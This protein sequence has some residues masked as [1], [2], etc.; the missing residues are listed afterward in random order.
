M[1]T[2]KTYHNRRLETFG[3]SIISGC[4]SP[5]AVNYNSAATVDDGSCIFLP[6]PVPGCM[7][8]A[9]SNFSSSANIDDGSCVFGSSSVVF[10]TASQ[11]T[12]ET[13]IGANIFASNISSLSSW[14]PLATTLA[15][16]TYYY[17][18]GSP[19]IT[20]S[21]A[22][23]LNTF[24]STVGATL[25]MYYPI[26]SSSVAA[27]FPTLLDRMTSLFT[28]ALIQLDQESQG[29]TSLT[30]AEYI[31]RSKQVMGHVPAIKASW[32]TA[33]IWKSNPSGVSYQRNL[34]LK[35]LTDTDWG[36]QY[37]QISPDAIVFDPV[38]QD[39]NLTL[40]NNY[41][42]VTLPGYMTSYFGMLT[43]I[44]KEVILQWHN[45]D[46]GQTQL[47]DALD[48]WAIGEMARFTLQNTEKF[49]Y[50][51]W[52][53][54]GN[55]ISGGTPTAQR[56]Y[57]SIKR[58]V[59]A[60]KFSHTMPVTMPFDG[61]AAQAFWNGTSGYGLLIT[62]QKSFEH[63]VV[64]GDISIPLKVVSSDFTKD[65]GYADSWTSAVQNEV[66]V[67]P[68]ILIRKNSINMVTFTAT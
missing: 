59:P 34:A 62:N 11:K 42:N 8:P 44:T 43:N 27:D 24:L 30:N 57:D 5:S 31:S 52:M 56:E 41:F 51:F 19:T 35:P 20:N 18:L 54:M 46:T 22:N 61:C 39:Y 63:T 21:T 58:I 17:T 64:A 14:T 47:G 29:G 55:L 40:L 25:A 32:D 28:I 37:E 1:S 67:S 49:A 23:T 38:D 10:D 68:S 65:S 53:T 3:A 60:F 9:A 13:E 33:P 36:R 26:Q 7:N 66:V 2:S 50:L 4:T 45:N 16:Q 48:N 6:T 15:L 12:I